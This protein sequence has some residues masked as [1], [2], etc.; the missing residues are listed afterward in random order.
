MNRSM[1]TPSLA[2]LSEE[3]HGPQSP[4]PSGR[5]S[6]F[7]PIQPYNMD[8]SSSYSVLPGNSGLTGSIYSSASDLQRSIPFMYGIPHVGSSSSLE[9]LGEKQGLDFPSLGYGSGRLPMGLG[10]GMI[11]NRSG[12]VGMSWQMDRH[13]EGMGRV[14]S[15][16]SLKI[17]ESAE[18]TVLH[19]DYNSFQKEDHWLVPKPLV[20]RKFLTDAPIFEREEGPSLPA[21]KEES[22]KGQEQMLGRFREWKGVRAQDGNLH[23]VGFAEGKGSGREDLTGMSDPGKPILDNSH[24]N[25]NQETTEANLRPLHS[26]VSFNASQ[27]PWNP[28]SHYPGYPAIPSGFSPYGVPPFPWNPYIPGGLPPYG[29]VGSQLTPAK[30]DGS[31]KLY[32]PTATLPAFIPRRDEREVVFGPK[33]TLKEFTDESKGAQSD[34]GPKGPS[35][36]SPLTLQ[37]LESPSLRQS[38]FQSHPGGQTTA[39]APPNNG[40]SSPRSSDV[41]HSPISVV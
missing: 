39:A 32:R 33:D 29:L 34:E 30:H 16:Q 14:P 1:S 5:P 8:K 6:N 27:I 12:N 10:S 13:G 18:G 24:L 15:T 28:Y 36:P 41:S 3:G 19:T 26:V 38:A 22:E 11:P 21:L 20:T 9:S 25:L 17:D 40:N 2:T 37:L 23:S 4:Q 7:T 31:P 35:G